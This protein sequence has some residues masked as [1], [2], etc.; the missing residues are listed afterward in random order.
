MNVKQ[1]AY[2]TYRTLCQPTSDTHVD[3]RL[4][5]ALAIILV[6]F[7]GGCGSSPAAPTAPPSNP[8]PTTGTVT[9]VVLTSPLAATG[10]LPIVRRGTPLTFSA[11]ASG[12]TPPVEF[13]WKANGIILRGWSTTPTFTW[14]CTT[15]A[16]GEVIASGRMYFWAEARSAGRAERDI[17]SEVLQ[18][19]VLDCQ[20]TDKDRLACQG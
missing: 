2:A 12:G 11:T 14:D 17:G 19:D 5:R 10:P 6:L 4:G 16:D 20:G 15:S 1:G 13:R 18:F 7:T 3:L 9:T 8:G